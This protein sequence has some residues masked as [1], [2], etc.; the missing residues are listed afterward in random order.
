[1]SNNPFANYEVRI[2]KRYSDKIKSFCVTGVAHTSRELTPFDRQVDFWYFSV[3]VA[4][5]KKLTPVNIDAKDTVNIVQGTIFSRDPYRITYLQA[6]YLSFTND[7]EG[8][9]DSRKVFD[10]ALSFANA[11]MPHVIQL[12]DDSEGKPLWNILDYIETEVS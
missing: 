3:L 5:K 2:P 8:I 10:F 4:V 9:S 12:L 1:M 11:G 7:V 6:I